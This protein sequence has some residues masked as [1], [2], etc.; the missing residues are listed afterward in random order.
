MWGLLQVVAEALKSSTTAWV[1]LNYSD[2]GDQGAEAPLVLRRSGPGGSL[3]DAEMANLQSEN[4][5]LPPQEIELPQRSSGLD[6]VIFPH[7]R[8]LGSWTFPEIWQERVIFKGLG[9]WVKLV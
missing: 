2:I 3:G 7:S 4:M 5:E 8:G 9:P 1:D 6:M